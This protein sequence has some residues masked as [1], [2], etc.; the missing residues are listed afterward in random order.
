MIHYFGIR[1]LSPAGAYYVREFLNQIQPEYILVEGGSDLTSLLPD[2]TREDV[3]LP[4]AIM[5]YSETVPIQTLLYPFAEYSPEYQAIRWGFENGKICRLIDL[6]SSVFLAFQQKKAERLA[7]LTLKEETTEEETEEEKEEE[8]EEL[9]ETFHVYDE[10]EKAVGEDQESYWERKFE[11]CSSC[12]QYREAAEE[13]GRQL[14]ELSEDSKLEWAE[15]LL[16]ERYMKYEIERA[17]KEAKKNSEIVVVTG[18]FHVDGLKTTEPMTKEEIKILP[19][20][21]CKSTL[22]PYSYFRLSK[23]SGYGAGN[24]APGYYEL[25]WNV[26]QEQ[27]ISPESSTSAASE[28]LCAIA[29]YQRNYGHMV[30]SAEVI[31]AIRL[32]N[33]L[34]AM[35]NS[36]APVLSDLRDAAVTCMGHGHFSEISMAT[37]FVEIGSKIGSLPDG[38][39]RTLIQE[40]FYRQ[41]K[42]LKLEKYRTAVAQNLELDLRENTRVKTEKAAFL[43]LNRSFFLHR[44]LALDISFVKPQERRQDNATW[45]ESF[46]LQWTPEAE[47]QTIEAALKGDTVE[48]AAAAILQEKLE[49][50][51]TIAEVA[52]IIDQAGLCGMPK[53]LLAAVSYLQEL[54]VDSVS[55][56]EIGTAVEHLSGVIRYGTIRHIDSDPLKPVISQML[57]RACLILLDS[58]Q[59]NNDAVEAMILAIDRCN[60]AFKQLDFLESDDWEKELVR[61]GDADNVNMQT[62][63]FATAILLESGKISQEALAVQTQRRLSVGIP[64]DLGAGWFEGLAK[65]NRYLLIASLNLWRNLSDYIDTLDEEEFRRALV[66]LRRAFSDFSSGQKCEIGENLGEI[67]GLNKEEISEAVNQEVKSEEITGL[68]EFD[69]GDLL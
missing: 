14:R 56:P 48:L 15:T 27:A 58:C 54:S 69:F 8:K 66:F 1:H 28:Y 63:G 10:L 35:K 62:A 44:L 45:A 53:L 11:H 4:A 42:E 18:A 43:D 60:N 6:P 2:L 3:I 16:R 33:A 57:Y 59:C 9:I 41:L 30:S 21:P 51:K 29:D 22:M 26:L 61:L 49:Q 5:A 34:A 65:K 50:S 39:S 47:I 38:V 12:A 7:N 40:D 24:K 17:Q 31:E 23:R 36:S 52:N 32:S 20:L 13:Y 37:A 19:S 64:A 67:W 68:D 25:L 46:V 55:L